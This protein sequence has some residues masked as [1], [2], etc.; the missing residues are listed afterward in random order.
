[1]H[2][3]LFH[4]SEER[5]HR[6]SKP[7]RMQAHCQLRKRSLFLHLWAAFFFDASFPL[8]VKP[9]CSHASSLLYCT[10]QAISPVVSNVSEAVHGRLLGRVLGVSDF[11]VARHMAA[12]E[13]YLMAS[14]NAA[15]LV[16]VSIT[17]S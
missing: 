7:S 8:F 3:V 10:L 5:I 6:L 12:C 16:Q 11:F 17:L 13:Q 2:R 4:L 14:Y 15:S 9:M 1:M